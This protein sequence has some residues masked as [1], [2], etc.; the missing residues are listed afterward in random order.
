M[1]NSSMTYVDREDLNKD[2]KVKKNKG[3]GDFG[4]NNTS[5]TYFK[6]EHISRKVLK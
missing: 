2:K 4:E 6:E 5:R 3:F 1:Q